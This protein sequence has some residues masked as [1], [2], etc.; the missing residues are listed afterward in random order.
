MSH[1]PPSLAQ[2]PQ[3]LSAPAP[4]PTTL[5]ASCSPALGCP[6]GVTRL[7]SW[8]VSYIVASSG[9]SLI[10]HQVHWTPFSRLSTVPK[11]RLQLAHAG[12]VGSPRETYTFSNTRRRSFQTRTTS[13]TAL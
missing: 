1:L 7:R 12:S 8:P 4:P 10:Q 5:R 13:M 6:R 3:S 2:P 11:W 9:L